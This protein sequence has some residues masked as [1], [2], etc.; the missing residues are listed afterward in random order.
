MESVGA[1]RYPDGYQTTLDEA[2]AAANIA[3]T[4]REQAAEMPLASPLR[5]LALRSA[6]RWARAAES[7]S[8]L[9][10]VPRPAGPESRPELAAMQ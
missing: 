5:A 2:R 6:S 1:E 3:E 7:C 8:H 10:L 9:S 4:L